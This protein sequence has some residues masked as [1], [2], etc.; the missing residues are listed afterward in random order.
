MSD[1]HNRKQLSFDELWAILQENAL[2]QKETDR[3][4][5]EMN[6]R[7]KETDKDIEEI[8]QIL[9]E[10]SLHSQETDKKFQE[11]GTDLEEIKQILKDLSLHS[12]ETDRRIKETDK[13]FQEIKQIFKDLSLQ[14]QETDKK[15]QETDRRMKETDK[16]M[17]ETDRKISKLGS[18]VGQIIEHVA[19]PN[20]LDKFKEVQ[21]FFTRLSRNHI[22]K[23]ERGN[24][25]AEIDLLLENE[26]SAL[27]ME[28]KSLFTYADVKDHLKRMRILRDY[29]D[30]HQENR[31]Y[32]GAIAGAM[33]EERARKFALESG[34]YVIEQTG[35][36]VRITAPARPAAW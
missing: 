13:E 5:K 36:Q 21:L 8:R 23:D 17:K 24:L 33:I 4:L 27:V 12:Q 31:I 32:I 14:S 10:L 35:E 20:I 30:K 25:L 28:I 16:Q 29:A 18:R 1:I 19:A 26:K 34:L 9:K 7:Q 22:I 11:T 6:L 15:F 2:Q 3:M